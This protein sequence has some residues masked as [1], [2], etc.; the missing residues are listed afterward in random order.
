MFSEKLYKETPT[1]PDFLV[2]NDKQVNS[3]SIATEIANQVFQEIIKFRRTTD[4]GTN[5]AN[6]YCEKC[7]EP[8]FSKILTAIKLGQPIHFVLPAFPGKSPNP[9]KVLGSLPDMA[10]KLALEFLQDLCTRVSHLYS[11]GARVI[12]C[13]DGRVF[14]DIIGMNEKDVSS[15]QQDLLKIIVD[16]ELNCISMFNLEDVYDGLSYSQMRIQ[17]LSSFGKPIEDL[18][19]KIRNGRKSSAS[20]DEKGANN[21]FCGIT[22]F[23]FEDSIFPGQTMSRSAIQKNSR[24]N[25]YEVIRR[26]NAW[27]ELIADRFPEAVRLSIHP[28]PCGSQKLG[29]RLIGKESWMTPWHGV[30]VETSS[31]YILLNRLKAEALGAKLILSHSGKPSHYQLMKEYDDCEEGIVT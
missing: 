12:L 25:A 6:F 15:Y 8:H 30:A 27:S 29:I 5:C 13:S 18:K 11:P 2:Q 4:S 20:S 23:L 14:S 19:Q 17:L 10:E 28:Q 3:V 26:S 22:R 9:S 1:S 24:S 31:G 21:M 7:R 16:H